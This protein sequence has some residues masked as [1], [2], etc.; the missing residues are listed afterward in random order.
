ME[1]MSGLVLDVYDDMEG[2]ILRG[3][4]PTP[5]DLPELTKE[6]HALTSEEHNAL[7]DEAFAL[8]LVDGDV[9]LKKFATIDAGNTA[10]SVGYFLTTSHK[11][12]EEAQKVAA[13]NLCAACGWYDLEPPEELRKMAMNDWWAG[14]VREKAALD[15]QKMKANLDKAPD[16]PP[17]FPTHGD[18][19]KKAEALFKEAIGPMGLML[20][21]AVLPHQVG[22]A[23][24]NLAATKGARGAVMTPGQVQQRRTQ[25]GAY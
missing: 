17:K 23:K 14:P 4:Y 12:P 2:T 6:A 13:Q 22:E 7:P 18:G 5:A 16:R 11:L 21:A 20:G 3:L 8:V 25:M 1:K 15:L 9:E 24:K 10:L 19:Y